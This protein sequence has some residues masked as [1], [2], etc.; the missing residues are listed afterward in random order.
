MNHSVPS[1]RIPIRGFTLVEV[2]VTLSV[3]VILVSIFFGIQRGVYSAQSQAKARAEMAIIASALETFKS[4]Y[5]DYPWTEGINQ[6]TFLFNILSGQLYLGRP[7]DD[8][9]GPIGM[10][11]ANRRPLTDVGAL[12]TQPAGTPTRI[13]DPWGNPYQY[14]YR[15]NG[16]DNNW[17]NP[18]FILLSRGENRNA[19]LNQPSGGN[20]LTHGVIPSNFFDLNHNHDVII[21]GYSN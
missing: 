14:F 6:E 7:P 11:A 17:Q 18:G 21:Y 13:V 3:I 1:I 15:V 19:T 10:Y 4:R 9:D 20:P 12:T 2:L 5:G 8:P 16:T